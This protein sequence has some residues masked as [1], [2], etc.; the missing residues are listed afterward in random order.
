M[1]FKKE[2]DLALKPIVSLPV[3]LQNIVAAD[4]L[5]TIRNRIATMQAFA[6]KD[7]VNSQHLRC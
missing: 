3:E 1:N 7:Q 2:L 5:A 4:I 6:A